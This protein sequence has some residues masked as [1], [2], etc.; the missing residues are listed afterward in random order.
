MKTV[1]DVLRESSRPLS[2]DEVCERLPKRSESGVAR[3]LGAAVDMGYVDRSRDGMYEYRA[4]RGQADEADVSSYYAAAVQTCD[5]CGKPRDDSRLR[6][7][8]PCYVR[9]KQ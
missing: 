1:E 3:A 4:S 7:C 9:S 2:L 6:L 5:E 8:T